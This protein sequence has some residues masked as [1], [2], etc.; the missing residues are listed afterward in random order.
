[1]KKLFL[2]LAL[3]SLALHICTGSC[4]HAADC[5][6]TVRVKRASSNSGTVNGVQFTGKQLTLLSDQC[7]IKKVPLTSD[8]LVK[9]ETAAFEKRLAK[10]KAK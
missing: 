6:L 1:M 5:S 10:L 7:S 3:F 2:L 8:E 9:L 4:A